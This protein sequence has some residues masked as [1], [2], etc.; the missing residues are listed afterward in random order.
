MRAKIGRNGADNVRPPKTGLAL[1][2]PPE[3]ETP[4][5]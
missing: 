5:P 2:L 4:R 3:P 1:A